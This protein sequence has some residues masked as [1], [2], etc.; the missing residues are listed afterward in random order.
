MFTAGST[1][2][3]ETST[4]LNLESQV[5][6][7]EKLVVPM[8]MRSVYWKFYG[9]PASENGEILTNLK[10]VCILCKNVISYNRNT[11]NLRMHLQNKH[12][13]ELIQIERTLPQ[14]NEE[15]ALQ[16]EQKFR[17]KRKEGFIYSTDVSGSVVIGDRSHSH[18]N[19]E[20]YEASSHL[21][22]SENSDVRLYG[23]KGESV[24]T[25]TPKQSQVNVLMS[26]AEQSCTIE[27]TYFKFCFRVIYFNLS[28]FLPTYCLAVGPLNVLL[29][30]GC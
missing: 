26:G 14:K 22:N 2:A 4:R 24:V 23:C 19:N 18:L 9:F 1:E 6:N 30:Y 8:S 5:F 13:E 7:Y 16:K 17:R 20:D 21:R 25:S 15:S 29:S 3:V 11:S 27:V 10:I 28:F 12:R